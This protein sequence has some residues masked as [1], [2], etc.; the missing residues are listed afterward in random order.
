MP[1][2]CFFTGPAFAYGKFHDG[3]KTARPPND[4]SRAERAISI[5][6]DLETAS[7]I[8]L[9]GWRE[10]PETRQTLD[11]CASAPRRRAGH[12]GTIIHVLFIQVLFIELA[13]G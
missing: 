10:A 3:F 12:P 1:L 9:S 8:H 6:R 7:L 4:I 2:T 5:N 13:L 11:R